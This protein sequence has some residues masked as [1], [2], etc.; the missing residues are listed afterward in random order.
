M[1]SGM[2]TVLNNVKY[3][4][5]W[6]FVG[7]GVFIF[8]ENLHQSWGVLFFTMCVA[9]DCVAL[10]GNIAKGE[11]DWRNKLAENVVKREKLSDHFFEI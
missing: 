1:V 6:L 10:L 2:L 8:Q 4:F 7:N 9:I 5:K 11:T 3:K